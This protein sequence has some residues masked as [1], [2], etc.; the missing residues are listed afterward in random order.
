[1]LL[2][3]FQILDDPDAD[4]ALVVGLT[5]REIRF[6]QRGAVMP[7]RVDDLRILLAFGQDERDILAGLSPYVDGLPGMDKIR[8][9][10]MSVPVPNPPDPPP[11]SPRPLH[12]RRP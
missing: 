3:R 11:R 1:M 6:L 12:R 2:G 5:P 10:S 7:L 4:E 9:M 8:R